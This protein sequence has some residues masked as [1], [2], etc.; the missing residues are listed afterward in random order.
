M[1]AQLVA[2][3][4]SPNSRNDFFL[5]APA[6]LVRGCPFPRYHL[7]A[8]SGDYCRAGAQVG[9]VPSGPSFLSQG[10]DCREPGLCLGGTLSGL[11][12]FSAK[13]RRAHSGASSQTQAAR[14][15]RS[16]RFSSA[17]TPP[18]RDNELLHLSW[19]GDLS[20]LPLKEKNTQT[21][22]TNQSHHTMQ[23]NWAF[24]KI[25]AK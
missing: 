12:G 6:A 25:T 10:P 15:L 11:A 14:H 4:V 1:W 3:G 7:K 2:L 19:N 21:H 17:I 22:K 23:A 13:G 9:I 16:P 5:G 24:K 20:T 8:R 18:S